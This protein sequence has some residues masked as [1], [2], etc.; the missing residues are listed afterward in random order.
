MIV[1]PDRDVP[2]TSDRI[3]AKPT[4]RAVRGGTSVT[5]SIRVAG[6]EPLD[7]Q[8][9]DT[10]HDEGPRHDGGRE[11]TRLDP[12]VDQETDHGDGNEA[13]NQI[14]QQSAARSTFPRLDRGLEEPDAVEPDDCEDGAELNEDLERLG[15]LAGFTQP[16]ADDDEVARRGDRNELRDAFHHPEQRRLE[17]RINPPRRPHR[18]SL[19]DTAP[20]TWGRS[21]RRKRG[22]A[23]S[24]AAALMARWRT[25]SRSSS[26][27]RRPIASTEPTGSRS[28]LTPS[29]I[30]SGSPPALLATTGAPQAIA[31]SA[32][33]P[34]DSV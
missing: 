20:R 30:T 25:G 23:F 2:G 12:V 15:A 33:R 10:A 24:T 8:N 31:S 5:A 29:S 27:A 13:E 9:Q 3:C 4:P 17:Q 7:E 11:E 34:N 18:V 28:P 19:H 16:V 21:A 6:C 32:A 22:W 14:E 26:T 1:A